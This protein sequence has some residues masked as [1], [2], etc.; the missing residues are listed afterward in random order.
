M[1]QFSQEDRA[2]TVINTMLKDSEPFVRYGG[3][4]TLAMAYIGTASNKVIQRLLTIAVEDVADDVRRSAVIALAFVLFKNYE[5]VPKVMRLLI[6]SYNPHIRYGTALALGIACAGTGFAEAINML[7]PMLQ[8][9]VDFVRQGT[10]ISMALI[11][12]QS[13]TLSEPKLE[14]YKKTLSEMQTKK[15]ETVLVKLGTYLA[16]GILDAGG[17]NV[18]VQLTSRQGI[19]KLEACIGMMLFTNY[20]FWFPCIPFIQLAMTPCALIGLNEK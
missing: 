20:W 10:L 2:E 19:P 18:L 13:T 14:S 12:M 17:R 4:M 15:H 11:L 16:Q 6:L 1:I 3:V 8:D 7:E 9:N 5:Q